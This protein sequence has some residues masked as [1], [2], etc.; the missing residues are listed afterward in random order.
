MRSLDRRISLLS[1][2]I[3]TVVLVACPT[4]EGPGPQEVDITVTGI[5]Q[6]DTGGAVAGAAVTG[7]SAAVTSSGLRS[8]QSTST[9]TDASGNFS[10]TV[11]AVLPVKIVADISFQ[12]PTT[13]VTID[14]AK[15]QDTSSA[16]VDLGTIQIP[17]PVGAEIPLTGGSGESGDGAIEI[18]GLPPEVDSLFG[19]SY[20][21]DATPEAF[22]GEFAE[23]GQIPLDS[24]NFLWM[25]ALDA[26]GNPVDDFASAVTIR[27]RI[28]SS[29][30]GD[31]EDIDAGTDRIEVPMY[32]FNEQ[33]QVWE[34]MDEV[35]WLEDAAGTILPEDAQPT[36]LDGSFPGELYANFSTDHLS[37]MNVDYAFIGP[38][39]LS[40]LDSSKRNNDCLFQALQLARTIAMSAAGQAAYAKYNIDG[41]DLTEELADGAGPEL[42]G[43][44]LGP[45]KAGEFRGNEQ[46]DRDD[47]LYLNNTL[48]GG[49]GNGAT[50][51]QKKN[52]ILLMAWNILHETAHWK[53]DVKH[54]GGT[55]TNREPS[56]EAGEQLEQDLF[57]G[58]LHNVEG[59]VGTGGDIIRDGSPVPDAERDRWL[60]P[61]NWPAPPSGGIRDATL[62]P[63]QAGPSP[64][65][66]TLVLIDPVVGLGDQITV[67]V[68]YT[69]VSASPVDVLNL[70]DLEGYPMSF[71]IVLD[72]ET[73]RVPFLGPRVN[74]TIDF[75]TDFNTLQPG[76]SFTTTIDLL[77]DDQT[78]APLY[79]ILSSG[80]YQ[81]TGYY[82]PF[83]GIPETQS[84]AV[85]L[86]VGPGG[87]ISGTVTSSSDASPIEGALVNLLDSNS[88]LLASATT[89][90]SGVYSFPEVP[91]GNYTMEASAPGFLRNTQTG[92]S[93][94]VN[95]NTVVNF[96]LSPLLA[97]GQLQLVLTWGQSPSDLD[98]HLWLPDAVPYHLYFGR[99]GL[100]FNDDKTVCP[101]A[102][103]DV[104]DTSSFGPETV[105]I[106]QR[107]NTGSYVYAI[108]N[109]SGTPDITTSEAQVQVFDATGLIATFD[110]PTTGTGLWWHVL[111]IDGATGAITEVNQIVDGGDT[112][113]RPAPGP[114]DDTDA[115]CGTQQPTLRAPGSE[116]K[117]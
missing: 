55:W 111:D 30:W 96:T 87:S 51:E 27:S 86:T 15:T 22:P 81:V 17:D 9:T 71:E 106:H 4:T 79:N 77:R 12:E 13:T 100:R 58:N 66:I 85:A 42:K 117:P 19:R 67:E 99:S 33:T 69:N 11:S 40:R 107:V 57:G 48:W 3:L 6:F 10:F 14:T 25:E 73:E 110:V 29:Q 44:D 116:N 31:L 49:C 45:T 84:N 88:F 23:N 35:G 83:Y 76:E 39:T 36:I 41:A 95:T 104:D 105:T 18:S 112:L 72:G 102:E 113:G 34:Q 90:I 61:S 21:P 54:D 82:S 101:W 60:D 94:T 75:A 62:Q 8:L 93:A 89:N 16:S 5:V 91:A 7:S 46:G 43:E 74:R 32:S 92:V 78:G 24:S 64:I 103:L 47:Q 115:G 26:S 56:G 65:E 53:W 80:D 108:Y 20:D 70:T 98:S 109:W 68:S 59:G 50:A 2:L 97:S 28:P 63:E 114:Y 52:T 37:W 1:I 38:W